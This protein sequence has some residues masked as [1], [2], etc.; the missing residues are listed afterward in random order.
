MNAAD[1]AVS[2]VRGS[3]SRADNSKTVVITLGKP[4]KNMQNRKAAELLLDVLNARDSLRSFR[5]ELSEEVSERLKK[6]ETLEQELRMELGKAGNSA[7]LITGLTLSP[8]NMS[9]V[10]NPLKGLAL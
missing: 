3:I 6:I 8:E 4:E 1:R 2:A 7:E 5:S 10:T 9:L